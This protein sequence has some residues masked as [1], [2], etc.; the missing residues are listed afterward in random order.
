M[1][2]VNAEPSS[3]GSPLC[4]SSL[5]G[6]RTAEEKERR[7]GGRVPRLL[8]G[9]R[10]SVVGLGGARGNGLLKSCGFLPDA[11]SYLA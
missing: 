4:P 7:L 5:L 1:S 8:Q 11:Q 3:R 6:S 9:S 10:L 2:I